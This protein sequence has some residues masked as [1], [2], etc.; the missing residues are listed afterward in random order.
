MA[1]ASKTFKIGEYAKGGVITA[2]V[3]GKVITIIG[4][5]WDTSAGYKK[6]SNQSKAKEF[7]RGTVIANER[8]AE[9]KLFFFLTDLT[10]AYYSDEIIKWIKTKTKIE[11]EFGY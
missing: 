7:T 10:T 2:E 3:N 6:S 1:K 9:Q 11:P 4:K 8:D 5:D